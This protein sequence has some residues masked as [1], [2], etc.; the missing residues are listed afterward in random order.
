MFLS[1]AIVSGRYCLR[2]CIVNFRTTKKDIE[3]SIEIIV[4][5]GRKV[6]KKMHEIQS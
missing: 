2:A 5:E 1:N 4:S 6:H 3:D